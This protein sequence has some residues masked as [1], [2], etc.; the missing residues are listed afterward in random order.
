M[1]G[2]VLLFLN[3]GGGEMLVILLFVLLFFG[4]KNLPDL[5][6]GLG[7]G[8]RQFKDAVNGVQYEIQKEANEIKR[9]ENIKEIEKI[10][11]DDSEPIKKNG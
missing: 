10:L 2:S 7:K 3:I 1:L 4:S 5:A 6:R 8:I 9:Q 11:K